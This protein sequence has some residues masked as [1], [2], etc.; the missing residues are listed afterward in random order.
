LFLFGAGDDAQ[1][2]AALAAALGWQVTVLDSRAHLATVVRF[3][4]ARAVRVFGTDVATSLG[5]LGLHARDAV[6][7]MTHS[8]A[9]DRTLL[10]HLQNVR[11]GYLGVLGPPRRT[12]QL[13]QD[14]SIANQKAFSNL[15]SPAG[16]NIGASGPVEIALAIVAQI[17]AVTNSGSTANI[18]DGTVG[19]VLSNG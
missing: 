18:A 5:A 15:Y 10:Q 17:Q 9:Q 1:P 14:A 6:V 19:K 7:L 2:V 11:A 13:L 12:Q 16:L 8:Y 3:P 4:S